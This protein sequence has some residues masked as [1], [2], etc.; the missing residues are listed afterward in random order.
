AAWTSGR[1]VKTYYLFFRRLIMK[2]PIALIVTL[3]M[4]L[5]FSGSVMAEETTET[6]S[7]AVT[8]A[9][10]EAAETEA[11]ETEAASEEETESASEAQ[12]ESESQEE[13]SEG[14]MYY[15]DYVAADIDTEVVIE[16]YVQAKQ[17]WWEDQATV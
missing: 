16:T 14:V 9:G 11:A 13:K 12:T 4:A 17:S 3:S 2:K 10:T 15:A 8:E 7:E 1:G 6:A 5:A